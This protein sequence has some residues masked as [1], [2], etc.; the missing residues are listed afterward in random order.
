MRIFKT[1]KFQ[2]LILPSC[3]QAQTSLE[4]LIY[5]I[6]LF[7]NVWDNSNFAQFSNSFDTIY[8][9]PQIVQGT[10]PTDRITLTELRPNTPYVISVTS[11]VDNVESEPFRARMTTPKVRN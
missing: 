6:T 1:C 4:T 7:C 2:L 3:S 8:V 5:N 10:S 9:L 11:V